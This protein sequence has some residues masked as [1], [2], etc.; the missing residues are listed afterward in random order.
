MQGPSGAGK[1][2]SALL[3]AVGLAGGDWSKV[4]VIDTERSADLYADLG[5]FLVL[6]PTAPFTPERYG[7]AL[8]VCEASGVEVVVLD[9]ISPCW[10]HLLDYH[11]SLPGNSFSNWSKVTP[12]HNAFVERIARSPLHVVAC[13]RAKTEYVLSEK[14]GKSNVPEKVGMKPIQRDGIEYEF[15]LVFE[16]DT[17]HNAAAT[18]DRTR[19]FA[20][21]PSFRL[22]EGTGEA[23]L[24]WCRSGS[25]PMRPADPHE[26]IRAQISA[27][28]TIADLTDLYHQLT[29][30]DQDALRPDFQQHKHRIASSSSQTSSTSQHGNHAHAA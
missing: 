15:T 23:L 30:A 10:E 16:L 19:L 28:V 14:N 21:Q 9:S 17:R 25:V 1:T 26:A 12:R 2:M 3:V 22:G 8:S 29:P 6:S 18:K 5:P 4:A 11:S 20:D 13:V 7:E 27:C 24:D